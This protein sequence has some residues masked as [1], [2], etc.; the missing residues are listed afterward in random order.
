MHKVAATLSVQSPS[1]HLLRECNSQY[2]LEQFIVIA[3]SAADQIGYGIRGD[4][5]STQATQ[6]APSEDSL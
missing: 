4:I 5:A 2:F 6:F 3:D 1:P